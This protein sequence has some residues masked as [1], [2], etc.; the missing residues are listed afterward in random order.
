MGKLGHPQLFDH[1]IPLPPTNFR[2]AKRMGIT[3]ISAI[4]ARLIDEHICHPNYLFGE[5]NEARELLL[6]QALVD[7]K[8]ESFC[9]GVLLSILPEEID[10]AADGRAERVV[11]E[12][13]GYVEDLLPGNRIEGFGL[14][15]RHLASTPLEI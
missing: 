10:D 8:H 3:V 1:R 14:D 11:A 5:G 12:V 6:R 4:P 13:L 7:S 2:T 15:L 9:R